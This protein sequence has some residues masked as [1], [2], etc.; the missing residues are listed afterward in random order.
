M[1]TVDQIKT[2]IS[3]HFS[4]EPVRFFTVIANPQ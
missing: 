3:S 1:A 2:L 4:E